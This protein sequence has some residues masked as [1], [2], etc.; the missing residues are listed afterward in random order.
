MLSR[1]LIT[2]L[3][4]STL[5]FSTSI[6]FES[7]IASSW[8]AQTT[9]SKANLATWKVQKEG[10]N[11][12]LTI[13]EIESSLLSFGGTFNLFFTKEINFKDGEITVDFRANSG[14]VD[15]GGGIMWRVADKDNYY[16]ARFNPLEDNFRFYTV[17]DGHRKELKSANVTLKSGWHKMKII[18]KGDHFEGYLDG[19]KLLEADNSSI[20]KSGGVGLWTKADAATSFDN[21][22]VENR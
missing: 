16:V 11:S 18:Q 10:K 20:T 4:F 3:T 14:K 9:G 5:L 21:F 19:K 2:S 22:K 13:T 15:Q 17:I 12:I 7:K 1:L 6:D 8:K